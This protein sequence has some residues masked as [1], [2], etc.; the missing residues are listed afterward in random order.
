MKIICIGRNYSDH[1]RELNNAVPDKPVW[2]MKPD[3]ALLKDNAPFYYPEFTNDLHYECELVLRVCKAGRHIDEAFAPGYMDQLSLGIDFTARDVQ[4]EKK[5]KGLP[6]EEA[7]AFDGSAVL[8]KWIPADRFPLPLLFTLEKNGEIVQTGN[9]ADMLF[10][11]AKVIAYVSRFITLKVG[12]LIY[13]GTP[14]GVGPV[15]I[16]DRLCGKIGEN[17]LFDF[18]IK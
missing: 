9:T 16:G 15:T 13:T 4:E 18:E 5:K 17:V 11:P 6:W 2:F 3:T 1:A 7:K 8:G 14:A 10:S 12:D